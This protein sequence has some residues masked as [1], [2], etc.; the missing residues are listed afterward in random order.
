VPLNS[1]VA[2]KMYLAVS[3]VIESGQVRHILNIY[4]AKTNRLYKFNTQ[5]SAETMI[6][7]RWK[8]GI[9]I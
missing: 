5:L 8:Y 6:G 3:G 4:S 2:D 7:V 9:L 1:F